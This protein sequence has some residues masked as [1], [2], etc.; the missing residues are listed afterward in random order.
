MKNTNGKGYI[1]GNLS[2]DTDVMLDLILT[3]KNLYG[4]SLR[5]DCLAWK[6]LGYPVQDLQSTIMLFKDT[7]FNNVYHQVSQV[8]NAL[9]HPQSDWI[10]VNIC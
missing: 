9:D 1:T 8:T 3:K 7:L 2:R 6:V 10:R 4:D 5:H